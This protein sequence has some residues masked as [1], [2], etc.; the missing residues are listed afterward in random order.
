VLQRATEG[1]NWGFV[2]DAI[3]DVANNE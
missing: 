3:S 1:W 2:G